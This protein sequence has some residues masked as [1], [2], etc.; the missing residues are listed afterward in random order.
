MQHI[1][2]SKPCM[3]GS[4]SEPNGIVA[5][6]RGVGSSSNR[7]VARRALSRVFCSVAGRLP[8]LLAQTAQEICR[9]PCLSHARVPVRQTSGG[10][11]CRNVGL[12]R[13]CQLRWCNP[14]HRFGVAGNI[15]PAI[16]QVRVVVTGKQ[17]IENQGRSRLARRGCIELRLTADEAPD[18]PPKNTGSLV[19]PSVVEKTDKGP[20]TAL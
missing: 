8:P 15:G 19:S 3:N 2:F 9:V 4:T 14:P 7:K 18:V 10:P 17:L 13:D 5:H 11:G 6:V 16:Q 20:I 12:P 1:Y